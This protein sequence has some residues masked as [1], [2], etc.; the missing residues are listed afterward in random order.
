ML[1]TTPAPRHPLLTRVAALRR[2]ALLASA[3]RFGR[4]DYCR[5]THLPRLL[6]RM[7]PPP[8][9]VALAALIEMED[10][11]NTARRQG[12]ATYVISAHVALLSALVAEAGQLTADLHAAAAQT[13]LERQPDAA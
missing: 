11:A 13:A 2:P 9:A 12:D 4:E 6:H 10:A 8:P 5:A 1:D 7:T 3:A